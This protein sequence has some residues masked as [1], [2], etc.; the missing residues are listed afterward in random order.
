MTHM[1]YVSPARKVLSMAT[2]LGEAFVGDFAKNDPHAL[3]V[4]YVLLVNRDVHHPGHPH[5]HTYKYTGIPVGVYDEAIELME[6][7]GCA[8]V[9]GVIDGQLIISGSSMDPYWA[10][11]YTRGASMEE[12]RRSLPGN[13]HLPTEWWVEYEEHRQD[14]I[15][16]ADV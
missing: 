7:T 15:A 10:V 6:V 2:S 8:P 12:I 16:W 5:W 9:V 13:V 11:H 3:W 1:N 4:A 14:A